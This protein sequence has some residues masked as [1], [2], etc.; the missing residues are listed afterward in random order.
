MSA[1]FGDDPTGPFFDA[2]PP[3]AELDRSLG[4]FDGERVAA[5]SG[6][7]SLEMTVPGGGAVPTA[8][9]TWVTVSPTHRRRGVLTAIMRRQLEETHAAE[10]E[11][12][13]AL[14]AAESSI[15]GRFGY[16]PASW[17]GGWTGAT[18][19][20]RLRSDVDTG[21]GTIRVVPVEEFRP[22]AMRIHDIVRR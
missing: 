19:R 22:E 21:S 8:G 15:Y 9:I 14:W 10:R 4:L 2:V 5:T 11:P 17:R 13:A 1:V 3:V 7:Y 16:A 20:L 18:E 6:I 12:V